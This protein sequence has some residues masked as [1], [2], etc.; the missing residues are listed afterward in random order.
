M[1]CLLF[2]FFF[3]HGR[4]G[5][6]GV[7]QLEGDP[8]PENPASGAA[9]WPFVADK[10]KKSADAILD[11]LRSEPVGHVRIAAVG[12]LTNLALAWRK[13]P[14]TFARVGLIS[15][16]GGAVDHPGNTGPTSEFNFFADAVAAQEL[17]EIPRNHPALHGRP[18]PLHILPLDITEQHVLPYSE[19]IED[20]PERRK[21]LGVLSQFVSAFLRGP[22]AFNNSLA[23]PGQTPVAA[24]FDQF[25]AHDPLA[26]AHAIFS[27]DG[28]WVSTQRSF[29]I[30]TQGRLTRGMCVVDRR[31]GAESDDKGGHN[32]ADEPAPAGHHPFPVKVVTAS[33]G[34]DW[35][36]RL[37]TSRLG[38]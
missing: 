3:S 5:L 32:R 33:P 4:D 38:I 21:S 10:T 9:A 2:F 23:P 24:K 37:F 7:S 31:S 18:L 35:F 1:S 19:L 16:M 26:V 22:R 29:R 12:P 25:Q 30:E 6:S 15:V 20:D 13:D 17:L 14:E 27:P 11:I 34:I 36:A 8:F 28:G